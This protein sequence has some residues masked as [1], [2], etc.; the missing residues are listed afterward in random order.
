MFEYEYVSVCLSV[1]SHA[2]SFYNDVIVRLA[3]VSFMKWAV[4]VSVLS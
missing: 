4:C 3:T 1:C 2:K